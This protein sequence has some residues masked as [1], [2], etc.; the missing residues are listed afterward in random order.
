MKFYDSFIDVFYKIFERCTYNNV[1]QLN[2]ESMT[3]DELHRKNKGLENKIKQYEKAQKESLVL[4]EALDSVTKKIKNR[5]NFFEI[6]TVAIES[7]SEILDIDRVLIHQIDYSKKHIQKLSESV[8]KGHTKDIKEKH[9]LPFNN[10]EQA[11]DYIIKTRNYISSFESSVNEF[12]TYSELGNLL[13]KELIIKSL[14]WYPFDFNENA[15]SIFVFEQFSEERIWS[16]D[17]ISF[18]GTVADRVSL[19]LMNIRLSNEKK[20]LKESE[21]KV[22]AIFES[23]LN[24]III[25]DDLGNY[26]FV[27]LAAAN[28]FGYSEEQLRKM[29]VAQIRTSM[30]DNAEEQYRQYLEKGKEIGEF[31]FIKPDGTHRT[32]QYH[33]VR[34]KDNFN[35]SILTDITERKS[36][37]IALKAS[38]QKYKNI[39]ENI[40]GLVLRIQLNADG[41]EKFHYLS[42]SVENLFEISHDEAFH[43]PGLMWQRIHPDD[44]QPAAD[45]LQKSAS[46]LSIWDLKFRLVMP[47]GRIKWVRAIGT[48]SKGENGSFFWDTLEIEITNLVK[49]ENELRLAKGKAEESEQRLKFAIN[50]AQLGIWDWNIKENTLIWNDRMFE[51]FGKSKETKEIT[52]DLWSECIHPE[53]KEKTFQEVNNALKGIKEFGSTFRIVHSDGK[54]LYIKG[55]G[56]TL[57]DSEGNAVRMIGINYDVTD[58]NIKEIE[59]KKSKE[60]AERIAMELKE[61]QKVAKFGSWYLNVLTNEVTWSD[62]LFNIYGYELGSQVPDYPEFEQLSTPE[63]WEKLN[64][65]LANTIETGLPYELELEFFRKDRS[66]GWMWAKGEAVFDNNQKVIGIRGVSQDI[67]EKKEAQQMLERQNEELKKTNYELD[68]FVYRI[69]HDLRAPIASSLGLI[70]LMGSTLDAQELRELLHLQKGSM[71]RLDNFIRDILDYSRNTRLQLEVE[72]IDIGKLAKESYDQLMYIKGIENI[73]FTIEAEG[74]YVFF[75]DK[76]RLSFIFNN[77]LSNSIRFH[78]DGKD[79]SYIR[80]RIR[81]EA[82]QAVISLS[83]NG[84]GIEEKHMEKIFDMFYRATNVRNGSGLG[85]YIVKES[86]KKL[87]GN[88]EVESK[89][90][91]GTTLRLTLP[92]TVPQ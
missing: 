24:S 6:I 14:L 25:A 2:M 12:F 44:I 59:L 71:L 66:H 16:E 18:L 53:D 15:F 68:N 58:I 50:S 61:S 13:H 89:Y 90:N 7:L 80:L 84:I 77:L 31:D 3:F 28:M 85:L 26:N 82:E 73:D 92:N 22:N 17:E 48:P 34:V 5:N 9:I 57:R 40:P 35:L 55:D 86:I 32:A 56:L 41:T 81:I 51:L 75:S 20:A 37:E 23:S 33:A 76:M 54:V 69:S 42:K 74:D 70:D 60:V 27:N 47:D 38:E 87:N 43:N 46:E 11:F 52:F 72:P 67:T 39:T 63:S 78:D 8:K 91:V 65:T 83:D 64:K 10:Y 49:A 4:K 45:A 62:E 79:V 19:A 30:P 1:I 88:I 29:N 21:E 36:A